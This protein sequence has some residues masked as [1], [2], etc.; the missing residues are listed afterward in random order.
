M[1]AESRLAFVLN[2]LPDIG[3]N[4][5]VMA[6]ETSANL[7]AFQFR[8]MVAGMAM[9]CIKR[10]PRIFHHLVLSALRNGCNVLASRPF[11][12]RHAGLDPASRFFASCGYGSRLGL[13][14]GGSISR[15]DVCRRDVRPLGTCVPASLRGRVRLLKALWPQSPRL[16]RAG[17]RHARMHRAREA[18]EALAARVEVRACRARQSRL[19]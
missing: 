3:S 9:S 1:R 2:P 14:H 16:G 15:R 10:G 11:L 7:T 4:E 12:L 8:S 5:G 17:R 13:H 6:K 19:V 18:A